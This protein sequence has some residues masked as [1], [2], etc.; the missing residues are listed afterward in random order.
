MGSYKQVLNIMGQI[1]ERI[2]NIFKNIALVLTAIMT[3]VILVQVFFR[4]F[5]NNALPWPE[6][7]ARF[8]MVWMTF[9]IAPYAYR[10]GMNVKVELIFDHLPKIPKLLVSMLL[11]I[12]I[13]TMS[14]FLLKEGYLMMLRGLK[15]TSSTMG[16]SLF[17][18]YL[19]LPVSFLMM[20]I[21]SIEKI[22]NKI[23]GF[24]HAENEP[25]S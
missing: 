1:N 13:G 2:L 20:F 8:M 11:H 22:L 9:L 3:A 15:I 12:F 5:L 21:V 6:E 16:I 19:I 18:V 14:V 23:G 24:F 7:A 4:Y 10:R 25:T 17:I